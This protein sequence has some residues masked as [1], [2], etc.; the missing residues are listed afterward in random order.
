[1]IANMEA[2]K[3][4]LREFDRQF[5]IPTSQHLRQVEQALFAHYLAE[6]IKVPKGEKAPTKK[7]L[8]QRAR[9]R[10]A[11]QVLFLF[12]ALPDVRKKAA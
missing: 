3:L 10:V 2:P 12:P 5:C 6:R 4:T 1:M 9:T 7:E 11:K 8:E